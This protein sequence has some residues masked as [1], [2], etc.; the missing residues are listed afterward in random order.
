MTT[1]I[2]NADDFGFCEAVNYGIISAFERGIVR[3]TSMMVNMPGALHGAE[4]LKQHPGLG[5][6]IHLTLSSYK[7]LRTGYKTIVDEEGMFYRRITNAVLKTF[8]L[9]E[10]YEE[11][12]AQI[13][14]ALAMGIKITHL[15]SHHHVH[16]LKGLE[17]VIKRLLAKYSYPIRGGFEYDLSYPKIVPLMDQFYLDSVSESF[18]EENIE[19]IKRHQVVDLMVHPAYVDDFLIQSTSY[20]INRTKEYGVLTSEKVTDYLTSQGIT[21]GNYTNI[22]EEL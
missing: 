12:C 8:D 22:E 1:L 6:G 4:L 20:A 5:C 18:F 3:S 9:E 15:D 16:T 17:P 11:F 2:V 21:L 10:V 7:P 14:T 13:E 19:L